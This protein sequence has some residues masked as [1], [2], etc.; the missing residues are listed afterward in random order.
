[1]SLSPASL[2]SRWKRLQFV[3]AESSAI[4]RPPSRHPS[5]M[6]RRT[7][8]A[9]NGSRVRVSPAESPP[10][11]TPATSRQHKPHDQLLDTHIP[12][13]LV[14]LLSSLHPTTTHSTPQ[15]RHP[16]PILHTAQ[17]HSSSPNESP[18]QPTRTRQNTN[19]TPPTHHKIHLP[20]NLGPFSPAHQSRH[21]TPG[22]F[23]STQPMI[24]S[25]RLRYSSNASF[26]SP[27]ISTAAGNT[28]ARTT[29]FNQASAFGIYRA[30]SHTGRR[31]ISEAGFYRKI[32]ARRPTHTLRFL[33]NLRKARL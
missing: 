23:L 3:T 4:L 18:A 27:A 2:Q 16:T 28:K 10:N 32:R 20:T 13:Q 15:T 29:R 22:P 6:S 11:S 1:M 8:N 21:L 19:A 12:V 26:A 30:A 24:R 25:G 17:D 7:F 9:L 5:P 33:L 14:K 31:V